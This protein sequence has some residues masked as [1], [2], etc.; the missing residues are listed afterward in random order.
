MINAFSANSGLVYKATDLDTLRATYGRGVQIPS[1][2]Q[3]G[4]T[5][6]IVYPFAPNTYY[7]IEGNPALK[8]TV[9]TNYELGYDRLVPAIFSTA[10]FSLYY[11]T[12]QDVTGFDAG[13]FSRSVGK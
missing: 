8:P 1:L 10:K 7:D 12:N 9:V 11:E 4:L 3:E 6:T 5:D 13:S 2:I